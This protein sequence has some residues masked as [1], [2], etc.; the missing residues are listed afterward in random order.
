[1]D[2]VFA[3]IGFVMYCHV[4]RASLY[5]TCTNNIF[6]WVTYPWD[7]ASSRQSLLVFGQVA[8]DIRSCNWGHQLPERIFVFSF[9]SLTNMNW[10]ILFH[11]GFDLCWEICFTIAGPGNNAKVN[12][13]NGFFCVFA[14]W[15][16]IIILSNLSPR[17]RRSQ[18]LVVYEY[19][20][21]RVGPIEV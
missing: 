15:F 8:K 5:W 18:Q 4:P 11:A 14:R 6:V 20:P 9:F 10:W 16:L 1:M 19:I 2:W 13:P 3:S 17:N 21:L 7:M 12:Y